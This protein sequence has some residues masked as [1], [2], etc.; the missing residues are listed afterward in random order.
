M[1][2]FSTLSFSLFRSLRPILPL[3]TGSMKT[4]FPACFA[5][6][7]VMWHCG[8]TMTCST[9]YCTRFH[10]AALPQL[11]SRCFK[12][13]DP[14]WLQVC[15]RKRI[16]MYAPCERLKLYCDGDKSKV[17][18]PAVADPSQF[19]LLQKC[20]PLVCDLADGE[21]LYIPAMWFHHVKMLSFG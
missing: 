21:V 7:A 14:R 17:G 3:R 18:D 11:Y 20:E 13:H 19:P 8:C 12:K 1:L 9:I 15:G 5:S 16:T 2:F 4:H 10:I 6:L